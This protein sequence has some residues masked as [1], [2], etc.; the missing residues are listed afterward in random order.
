MLIANMPPQ[1]VLATHPAVLFENAA[2]SKGLPLFSATA[3]PF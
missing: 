1:G 2:G 3:L